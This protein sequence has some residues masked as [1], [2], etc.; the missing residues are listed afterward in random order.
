MIIQTVPK[1]LQPM[2]IGLH[3]YWLRMVHKTLQAP[4]EAEIPVLT[5]EKLWHHLESE[6][7][8]SFAQCP[9]I[10]RFFNGNFELMSNWSVPKTRGG[11]AT[12]NSPPRKG[13]HTISFDR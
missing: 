5:V 11:N 6:R 7:L 4:E 3:H 8:L 1:I 13:P 9:E 12:N 2:S 10:K